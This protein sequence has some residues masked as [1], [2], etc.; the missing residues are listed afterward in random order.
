MAPRKGSFPGR[1]YTAVEGV[2]TGHTER[3]HRASSRKG[4]LARTGKL[5][6]QQQQGYARKRWHSTVKDPS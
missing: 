5:T 2:F 6:R 3:Q 1:R 4:G